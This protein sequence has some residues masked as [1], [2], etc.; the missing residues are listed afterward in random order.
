VPPSNKF[1]ENQ[2]S[3]FSVILLTNKQNKQ[4]NADENITSLMEVI[5]PPKSNEKLANKLAI[6]LQQI[7]YNLNNDTATK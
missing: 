3:S 6:N 2:S 7:K 4:T 1:Y 5:K